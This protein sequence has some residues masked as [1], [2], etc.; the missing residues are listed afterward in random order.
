MAPGGDELTPHESEANTDV[1][2][3]R[4][5]PHELLVG[6]LLD[7]EYAVAPDVEV[8][9]INIDRGMRHDPHFLSDL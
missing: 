2:T 6:F 5:L 8:A 1:K 4:H 7:L 9:V 3:K